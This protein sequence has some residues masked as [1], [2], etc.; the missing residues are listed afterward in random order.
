M[1]NS[2]RVAAIIESI[3]DE[4][5]RNALSRVF[6]NIDTADTS[7][8][9]GL[10]TRAEEKFNEMR[11]GKTDEV[12]KLIDG[13]QYFAKL[14]QDISPDSRK[15]L[16][17]TLSDRAELLEELSN[18]YVPFEKISE[19]ATSAIKELFGRMNIKKVALAIHDVEETYQRQ[20]HGYI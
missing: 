20:N 19:L 18:Y 9:D 15:G 11:E 17:D 12:Q 2:K 13:P 16:M 3:E 8:L 5:K 10:F 1:F 7:T 6:K 4:G 14:L